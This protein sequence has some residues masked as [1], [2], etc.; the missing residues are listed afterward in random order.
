ADLRLRDA[1]E[2]GGVVDSRHRLLRLPLPGHL[3]RAGG[4]LLLRGHQQRAA[5]CSPPV[6]GDQRDREER[7]AQ[8]PMTVRLGILGCA[9]AAT[10]VRL[11]PA[12]L[13]VGL[14][15][16]SVAS[17]DPG[18]AREYAARNGVPGAQTYRQMLDDPGIEAVYIPLPNSMHCEWAIRALAAGKAV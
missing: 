18:R 13:D 8:T 14:E 4:H 3:R 16:V 2:G 11:E 10:Y 6:P 17:R 12:R 15:V 7:A 9:A 1:A 5:R